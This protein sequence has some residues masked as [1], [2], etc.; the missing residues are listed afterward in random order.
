MDGRATYHNKVCGKA[1]LSVDRPQNSILSG[2][3]R[4]ISLRYFSQVASVHLV[5]SRTKLEL[6]DDLAAY[7]TLVGSGGQGKIYLA[8]RIVD[9]RDTHDQSAR[10]VVETDGRGVWSRRKRGEQN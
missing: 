3:L 1:N 8:R 4:R 9:M 2:G 5:A 7:S 6:R 10:K